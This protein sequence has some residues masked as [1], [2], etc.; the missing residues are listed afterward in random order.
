MA[1]EI[2]HIVRCV[3]ST[4]IQRLI[5]VIPSSCGVGKI[6]GSALLWGPFLCVADYSTTLGYDGVNR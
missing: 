4:R 1:A 5:R 2:K 6:F 3:A